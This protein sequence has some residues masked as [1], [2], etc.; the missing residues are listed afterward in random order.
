MSHYALQGTQASYL[1]AR[2]SGEDPLIWID[3]RS[4]GT[5][6]GNAQW[7]PLWTYAAEYEHPRWDERGAVARESGHGG[8]DY[9]ILE[10][11][12]AA[13]RAGISPIDVYDAVTW[14][15]VMPLSAESLARGGAPVAIPDFRRGRS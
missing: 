8:G 13:V 14:S 4:P 1:S 10:D 7:E 3:G 2:H 12:A 9:F 11:F 5:S 6:P 15:S